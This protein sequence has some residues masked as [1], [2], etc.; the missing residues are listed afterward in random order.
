MRHLLLAALLATTTLAG[1]GD[2]N[3][4]FPP[5]A[6]GDGIPDTEDEDADGNGVP[7]D[8]EEEEPQPC[9]ICGDPDLPPGTTEPSGDARIFR[10]EDVNDAGGGFVRS[11]SY[12]AGDD[13]FT[14][15]NLAFDGVNVYGRGEDVA[16]LGG[17]AV[18]EAEEVVIDDVT[19][20][21]IDQLAYRAI[22]GVSQN[23][24]VVDGATVPQTGFAIVRTGSYVDYG[25]GGFVYERNG[26]VTLPTSGQALFTGDYAGMRVFQNR[27][28]LEYTRADV[29]ISI[30]FSDFDE[31]NGVRGTIF[32]REAFAIDGTPIQTGIGE[33]QLPLPNLVF[34]IG[35]GVMT[36]GG[37][38]SAGI[39]SNSI[40]PDTGA[41]EAYE[42]GTYYGIIAGAGADMEIVGVI[43]IESDDPRFEGV[44]AQETGGFIVYR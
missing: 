41:L 37:E 17:Y 3:P 31:G 40:D 8:E 15:D 16:Q 27:G 42:D 34:E 4:F 26:T 9:V 28:G 2:G 33:G 20:D 7:D 19:G 18:Y 1:C 11:V 5:D 21:V 39:G 25:F 23:T 44:T 24:T 43:V 6:D 32:N 13:T 29:R 38:I 35:P 22:Y 30:D 14:V 12:N 10:Y 36:D